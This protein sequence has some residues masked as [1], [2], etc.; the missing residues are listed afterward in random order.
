[1]VLNKSTWAKFKAA[2]YAG[3][4]PA[5]PFEGCRVF[6]DNT[7]PSYTTTGTANTAWAI[8]GDFGV[9]AQANFPNGDEITIKYDNLSLAEKDLVKVVGREY[10][11]LGAVA[12]KAFTKIVF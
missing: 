2:Y 1:M 3:N 6:F 12:H 9:G 5:D 11:A 10:I 7:L 4:F 8:V